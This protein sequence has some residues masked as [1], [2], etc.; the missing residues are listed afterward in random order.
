[1]LSGG[2]SL[3]FTTFTVVKPF[4]LPVFRPFSFAR[5]P[6]SLAPVSFGFLSSPLPLSSLFRPILIFLFAS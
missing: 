6:S 3:F 5:L 1:M 2:I 4:R